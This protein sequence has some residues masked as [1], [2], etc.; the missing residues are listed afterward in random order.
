VTKRGHA[1]ILDFGLAKVTQP[2]RESGSEA[3]SLGQTTVT[4]EEHLTSPGATVGTVAYMSPEQVR[5]KEL[6]ARTDLFS[7]GAVLYE[8]ATGQLPFHGESSGVMFKAILDASPHSRCPIQS[9][10]ASGTGTDHQ[11]RPGEGSESA[12]S[13]RVRHAD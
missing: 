10:L 6:N 4:L 11:P 8:M 5:A 2:M 3:Q 1:K 7:F 13:A 12:L 9:G